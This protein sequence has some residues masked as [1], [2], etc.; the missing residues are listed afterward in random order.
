MKRAS[1][2]AEREINGGALLLLLRQRG[3]P[4]VLDGAAEAGEAEKR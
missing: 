3:A 2:R 1:I 4:V